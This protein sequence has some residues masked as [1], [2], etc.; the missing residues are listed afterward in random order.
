[1]LD[2]Q[3]RPNPFAA[4]AV[5]ILALDCLGRYYSPLQCHSVIIRRESDTEI[6]VTHRK[7]HDCS[8][9]VS[10]TIDLVPLSKMPMQVS[11]SPHDMPCGALSGIVATFIELFLFS[12]FISFIFIF[13]FIFLCTSFQMVLP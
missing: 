8:Y 12:V 6:V 10:V 9:I 1:M 13:L 4:A 11:P 2:A 7:G 3:P 5:S